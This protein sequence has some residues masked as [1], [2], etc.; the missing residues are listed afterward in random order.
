[1]SASTPVACKPGDGRRFAGLPAR[2][3]ASCGA[4]LP[5]K[6]PAHTAVAR[7]P[8]VAIRNTKARVAIIVTTHSDDAVC[9]AQAAGAI[10]S[11][12][13]SVMRAPRCSSGRYAATRSCGR[14]RRADRKLSGP[15]Q[16]RGPLRRGS[17]NRPGRTCGHSR[18]DVKNDLT[19]APT[20]RSAR[21]TAVVEENLVTSGPG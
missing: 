21:R 17:R 6:G 18:G 14:P 19:S 16:R 20:A 15:V 4:L 10:G 5:P 1:M 11:R 3:S 13:A 8:S 9:P 7:K 12:D 2:C